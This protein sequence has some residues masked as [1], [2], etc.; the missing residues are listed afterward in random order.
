MK[1][2][3]TKDGSITFYN[4][5]FGEHYHSRSGAIEEALEKYVKPSNI[6]ELARKESEVVIFDICFGL[7]YNTLMALHE[8]KKV[9]P[10]CKITVLVFENHKEIL[11]KISGIN[12]GYS[13]YNLIKQSINNLMDDKLT[14]TSD[15]VT[16]TFYLGD[17]VSEIHKVKQKA[18]AVFFDPFSMKKCPEMWSV[19]FFKEIRKRMKT[20]ARLTNFTCSKLARSQMERAGFKVID[21]PYVGRNTPSTIA[22]S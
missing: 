10:C 1:E 6:I 14:T 9:N 7:G 8:I 21:G 2:V 20:G 18:D 5:Q 4:E 17:A 16:I 12:L 19:E 13:K 22:V 15:N 3:A 11:Q